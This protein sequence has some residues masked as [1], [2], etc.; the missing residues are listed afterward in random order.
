[1][2]STVPES[3]KLKIYAYIIMTLTLSLVW[4]V[5]TAA[6]VCAKDNLMIHL[7]MHPSTPFIQWLNQQII[8]QIDNDNISEEK[9]P[10]SRGLLRR[11]H[12]RL[13]EEHLQLAMEHMRGTSAAYAPFLELPIMDV[14]IPS[15]NEDEIIEAW[16]YLHDTGLAYQ[17]QGWFGRTAQ[18]LLN[19]GIITNNN[20]K[21]LHK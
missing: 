14:I 7:D 11:N 6:S 3:I 21:R 8:D 18:D 20:E 16:Q 19:N 17:L 2:A 9:V 1:M 10:H 15:D 13:I 12:R 4:M 5:I